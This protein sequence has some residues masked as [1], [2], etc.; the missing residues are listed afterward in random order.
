MLVDFPAH[1][2]GLLLKRRPPIIDCREQQLMLRRSVFLELMS[3]NLPQHR[4]IVIVPKQIR[5][6]VGA[7]PRDLP[8]AGDA[9]CSNSI[10]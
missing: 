2:D 7:L 6:L 4:Q 8:R 10:A 5:K 3:R 1:C 9:H